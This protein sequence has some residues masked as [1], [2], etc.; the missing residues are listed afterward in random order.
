MYFF[1]SLEYFGNKPV[2]SGAR[3][4]LSDP[5]AVSAGATIDYFMTRVYVGNRGDG[6]K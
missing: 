3:M 6:N 4:R 2:E 5:F 1:F